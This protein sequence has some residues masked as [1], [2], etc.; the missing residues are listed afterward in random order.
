MIGS[1]SQST[2]P[3]NWIESSQILENWQFLY[4]SHRGLL[5]ARKCEFPYARHC[6]FSVILN[7]LSSLGFYLRPSAISRLV[8]GLIIYRL[9]FKDEFFCS[10][11][12]HPTNPYL[13]LRYLKKPQTKRY[14]LLLYLLHLFR[15][16]S[17]YICL[18]ISTCCCFIQIRMLLFWLSVKYF[19]NPIGFPSRPDSCLVLHFY[20]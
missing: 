11:S 14:V 8:F 6:T 19:A 12:S 17:L 2:F 13:T 10:V 3:C 15:S 4:Y 18:A 5:A 16:D 20:H 7:Y 1:Y 9:G